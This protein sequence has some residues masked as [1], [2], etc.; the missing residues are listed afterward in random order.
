[1]SRYK[2]WLLAILK[3]IVG[4]SANGFYFNIDIP[5]NSLAISLKK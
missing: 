1:M 4:N 2:T 3:S 5:F